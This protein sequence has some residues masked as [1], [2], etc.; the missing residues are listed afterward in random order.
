[1]IWGRIANV[2]NPNAWASLGNNKVKKCICA[3]PSQKIALKKSYLIRR[4]HPIQE[5]KSIAEFMTGSR[6]VGG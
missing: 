5:K 4:S 3:K 1:M 2:R 6:W